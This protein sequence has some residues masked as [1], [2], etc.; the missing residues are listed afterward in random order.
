MQ[1]D[2]QKP[3]LAYF[4]LGGK[5]E[6]ARLALE[7]AGVDYHYHSI[8]YKNSPGESWEEYKNKH[9]DELTFGQIPHYKEPGGMLDCAPFNFYFD[10]D[11]IFSFCL[12]IGVSIVQSS[13][14]TRYVA[15][16]YGLNG[17]NEHEAVAIDV[18]FEGVLD[19][20]TAVAMVQWADESNRANEANNLFTQVAPKHLANFQRALEHNHGGQGKI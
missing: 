6:V 20:L 10:V 5:G 9:A 8:T 16:K 1:S 19:L 13:S 2:V 18:L 7:V 15:R 4:H 14:I 11:N 12:T 17:S 3:T